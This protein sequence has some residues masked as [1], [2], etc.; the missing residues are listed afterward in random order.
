MEGRNGSD[1]YVVDYGYGAF[2]ESN[3]FA[4]DEQDDHILLGILYADLKIGIV[5][6]DLIIISWSHREYVS[7][8]ILDFLLGKRYQ[9]LIATTSDGITLKLEPR[10]PYKTV[11]IVDKSYSSYSVTEKYLEG[12]EC[13]LDI[14]G[15][16]KND[17]LHGGV[18]GNTVDGLGGSD[19]IYGHDGNDV[20]IGGPGDDRLYG[21]NGHD[22]IFGGDG[23]DL[24]DG[25][26]GINTIVFKGDGFNQMGVFVD[27]RT[28]KGS[29]A[30]ADGDSYIDI[31]NIFGSEYNDILHG[32][33]EDN[34]I[35]G[36][37]G[38]DYIH[39]YGSNDIL[40]G[41]EGIDVYNCSDATG[42]KERCLD[43]VWNFQ[44]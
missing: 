12:G 37:Q 21:G 28:G 31:Q 2:N 30:D 13:T 8:R 36:F 10:F 43:G 3:N 32:N 27:L 39:P 17:I 34:V 14:A 25:G 16:E 22:T 44:I 6:N 38:K 11:L 33:D 5:D 29:D 18:L 19:L 9:H 15:G 40:T 41:G 4:K 20:L 42:R 35:N 24:I 23:G 26:T 1:T 7:V